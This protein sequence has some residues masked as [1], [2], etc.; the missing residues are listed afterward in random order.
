MEKR[1]D[2][3]NG[4]I[5]KA[6]VTMAV[7]IMGTSLLQIAYSMIDMIWIGR[8]G[9]DS[10]AAVGA[11]GMYVYLGTGFGAFMKVGGQVC[12]ARSFGAGDNQQAALYAR[13]A[14][15]M[16]FFVSVVYGLMLC[17]FTVP[18]TEFFNFTN[19]VVIRETEIYLFTMGLFSFF[20]I[21]NPIFT[22]IINATSNSKTPFK[23]N[24][25]GLLINIIADPVLIFGVGPIPKLGVLGAAL[26]TVLGQIIV[27]LLFLAYFKR[28][29]RVFNQMSFLKKM[30]GD[31]VWEM[32][33]IGLPASVQIVVFSG[34]SIVIGRIIA[35][36]GE[37]AVAVQK[38]GVQ[39]ESISYTA[40]EGFSLATNSFLAQNY[41]AKKYQRARKGYKTALMVMV[42]WGIVTTGA[43]VLFPEMIFSIFIPDA[44]VIPFGADYLRIVGYS[45]LFMCVEILTAG[46]FAAYGKATIPSA[47]S[48]VFT[49]LRIP[50]ALALG[51]TVLGINGVWW[52]IS[53]SSIII[54]IILVVVFA[55]FINKFTKE[56]M[57][58][59]KIDV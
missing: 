38:V 25:I 42:V 18:L 10:V 34:I 1:L 4:H 51:A 40:A 37:V 52:A 23:I 3:L 39:I 54:G 31:M 5:L 29:E 17:V 48:I 27:F 32:T 28:D 56:I 50:A 24:A 8:V 9:A 44:E 30:R 33:K 16:G 21:I 43:M 46:A 2:L 57:A 14:I 26:A 47:V 13:N 58:K 41:G 55:R 49:T 6:L 20:P 15:Q 45:Q 53:S 7:P 19:A 36:W 11:A 35:M 12:V 22:A 59:E